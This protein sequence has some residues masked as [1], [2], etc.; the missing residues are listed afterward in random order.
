MPRPMSL[1]E[2]TLLAE[3]LERS[4]D[5]M[6]DDQFPEN[7]SFIERAV[8]RRDGTTR[9]YLYYQGYRPGNGP[10]AS[11]ARYSKYVGPADD[12]KLAER[13]R[14]FQEI[15]TR[16]RENARLV[17]ALVGAGLPRPPVA[18]GRIIEALAKA[19]VFRLRAA[20]VGT[21]AYQVYPAVLGM[22]LDQT[23]AT[24]GIV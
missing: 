14:R 3:L 18:M 5:E 10:S 13:V 24:T 15:K 9:N 6:F 16:R 19:G 17:D 21:A 23:S 1:A 4:L 2:H 12:A 8:A 22:R 20:L 11:N 7:G